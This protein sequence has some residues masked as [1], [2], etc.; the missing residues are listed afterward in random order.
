[1]TMRSWTVPATVVRVID[2][3][4]V[5]LDLDLGW[6][7]TLRR[8]CR[9]AGINAPERATEFGP[10]A[11]AFL[12]KLLPVGTK[13]IF[14]STRLDKYGRPLGHITRGPTDIE[15]AMIASGHAAPV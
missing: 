9:L 2:G 1:M 15:L 4:T 3:D 6:H 11:T 7:L 13:V 14:L 8:A 5:E 10:A 12:R